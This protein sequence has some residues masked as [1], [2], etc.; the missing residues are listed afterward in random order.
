MR[1]CPGFSLVELMAVLA[2]SA[3]ALGM[4]AL[5]LTPMESALENGRELTRGF[6][7]RAR[8]T[9]MATTSAYRVRPDGVGALI[10]ETAPSCGSAVWTGDPDLRLDLARG[11]RLA[12]PS[13]SICF[14]SR[15]MAD[16]NLV[17][18]LRHERSGSVRFEVLRGGTTRILP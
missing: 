8:A 7:R 15:G 17:V 4:L 10:A 6:L 5:Y 3:M 12:D 16:A 2:V 1:R 13:W 14:S 11:I 9:A 18:E